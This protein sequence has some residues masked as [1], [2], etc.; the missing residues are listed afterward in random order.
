MRS[1]DVFPL[2][3]AIMM[4]LMLAPSIAIAHHSFAPHFDSTRRVNIS[5]TVKEFDARNPHSYLHI[6]TGN[7][8]AGVLEQY[9][10]QRGQPTKG[11]L[12][13]ASLTT[14]E[15]LHIDAARQRLIVDVDVTDPEF[16]KQ[17]LTP[18]T[19]EYS[20]SDLKIAP[21]KCAREGLTGMIRN[22]PK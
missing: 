13:S 18:M 20:P 5:G 14:I 12:H 3:A 21:F 8:S 16:Y 1:G 7:Y 10:E 9:V 6:A 4:A 17:P 15:R 22:A 19:M 11:L 2:S